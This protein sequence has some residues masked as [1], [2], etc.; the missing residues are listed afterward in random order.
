MI[1]A[2]QESTITPEKSWEG[3][4]MQAHCLEIQSLDL[5]IGPGQKPAG[6]PMTYGLISNI[7]A[8]SAKCG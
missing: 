3:T 6:F 2:F 4:S 1:P 5:E 8:L 7:C